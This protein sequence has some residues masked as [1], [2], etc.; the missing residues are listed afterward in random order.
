MR[1]WFKQMFSVAILCIIVCTGTVLQ[2]CNINGLTKKEDV[3]VSKSQM[4]FGTVMTITL[5]GEEKETTSLIDEAFEE[6]KR[7]EM[8]F[9]AK[10]EDS[11]LYRLNETA[12]NNP[13]VVS[14][15][16]YEV[17]DKALIYNEKSCGALDVSIGNIV[18]LWAIGTDDERI[19][20]DEE[21]AELVDMDG[22]SYICMDDS[23]KSVEYKDA[24]VRLDLGAIAKGYAADAIKAFILEK[25]ENAYGILNFGGNIMTIG[26][27]KNGSDWNI[28][29]TN[30]VEPEGTFA[31]IG[32]KDKCVVTSG[33]YE[34]YFE[35]DGVR[36]HHII[37][38]KTGY[39]ARSGVL[40]VSVI[41]DSS[42]DCDALSTACFVLGV[43]EGLRLIES[44]DGFEA[45]FVDEN[46]ETHMSDGMDKYNF[47][48]RR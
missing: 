6:L 33:N 11:E 10:K 16:L 12:F 1:D 31:T 19:P 28:A 45:V 20:S 4:C 13:V 21:L 30:P 2:G 18:L 9:S 29:I 3:K 37:D 17:I 23:K 15:E 48:E 14:T 27:K 26:E 32:I 22:C 42:V 47:T 38:A 35:R 41:G 36:Y 34:R 25:N 43:D 7:L 46:M 39:P 8:I 44:L 24:R 5:F 40:S